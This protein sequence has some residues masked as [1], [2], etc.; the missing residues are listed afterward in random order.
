MESTKKDI[1]EMK[2]ESVSYSCC[3][4]NMINVIFGMVDDYSKMTIAAGT[5]TTNKN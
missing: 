5:Q 4:A 1:L 3:I 2:S